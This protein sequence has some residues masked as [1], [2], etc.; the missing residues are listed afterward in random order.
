MRAALVD[1]VRM[2]HKV[3]DQAVY[4][5]GQEADRFFIV[6]TGMALQTRHGCCTSCRL[7]G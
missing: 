7:S 1:V 5:A 3:K 6:L 2:E 4:L